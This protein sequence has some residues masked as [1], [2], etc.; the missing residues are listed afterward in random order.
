MMRM[1]YYLIDDLRPC[2]R[3]WERK[4]NFLYVLLNH[5]FSLMHKKKIV[6]DG[7]EPTTVQPLKNCIFCYFFLPF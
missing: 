3:K 5:Q 1:M 6:H 4:V 7:D 2:E